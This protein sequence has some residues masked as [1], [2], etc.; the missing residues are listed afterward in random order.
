MQ[1]QVCP[2]EVLIECPKCGIHVLMKVNQ[3]LVGS[4]NGWCGHF[5]V[6]AFNLNVDLEVVE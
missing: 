5:I 6:Q 4:D 3:V 1:I 2:K